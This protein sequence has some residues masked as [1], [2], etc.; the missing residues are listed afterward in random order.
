[1][2]K[3]LVIG[4]LGLAAVAASSYGQGCIWLDNYLSYGPIFTYGWGVPV[5]GVNGG[6]GSGGLNGS[7]IAGI[8]FTIGTPNI[9]DPAGVRMPDAA[10]SLGTGTGS[11]ALFETSAFGTPGEFHASQPFN[12]GAPVGSTITLEI[13]AYDTADGSYA[14]ALY[15]MHTAPFTMTTASLTNPVIPL[16]GDAMMAAGI[17][18]QVPV[19]ISPEPGT[20]ALVGLGLAYLLMRRKKGLSHFTSPVNNLRNMGK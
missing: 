11:T 14:A 1:M 12:T 6:L 5:N 2:K 18:G 17:S 9:T 8:Y 7:W 19:L 20:L 10:L 4:I 3:S 16:V 15:R 13:V